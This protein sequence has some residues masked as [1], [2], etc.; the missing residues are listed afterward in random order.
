MPTDLHGLTLA[1]AAA[2]RA[3]GQGNNVR[4][5]TSRTYREIIQQNVVNFINIVLFVIGAVMISIG[6]YSDAFVSVGLIAMNV[7]IGVFQEIRAKRQ[8]DHIALLTRPK[9]TLR[10]DGQDTVVDPSEVVLGDL[11][12]AKPG[13]QI[14]VDGLI[15]GD[16]KIEADESLLTGESDLI[17]KTAGDEVL[18]GSYCVTGSALYEATRV[19]AESFANKMAEG[20][21]SFRV[22]K[23]PLQR[24][25][26]F[27]IRVL[28]LV[29]LFIG[30]LLLVS[31]VL[32][33]LPVMRSVQM[34][35]VIAGLVPNGLF[36][37]VIL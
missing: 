13:D 23:T 8:L 5:Q 34:A 21:R 30:F 27:V 16:G 36:F 33:A 2:R 6:R 31:A 29:A 9:V 4:L 12:V 15:V 24:D 35:A 18:S 37:M 11:L 19:G 7:V 22:V 26:D 1:E 3:R 32:Y 20:A 14:V 17:P 28:T 25:I 10:R